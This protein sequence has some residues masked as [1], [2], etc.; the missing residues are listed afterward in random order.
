MHIAETKR[1]NLLEQE[2][3]KLAYR[4]PALVCYGNIASLTRNTAGSCQGDTAN[5]CGTSS[6]RP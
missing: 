3:V 4:S 6:M 5:S 1:L 2:C